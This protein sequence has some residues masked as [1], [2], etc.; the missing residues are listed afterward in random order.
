M[1][2]APRDTL[3][4]P[5]PPF[6]PI[7]QRPD[8]VTASLTLV[9]FDIERV[10]YALPAADVREI[11]RAVTIVPLPG[12]PPVIEGIIDVRGTLLPVADIRARL[13]HAARPVSPDDHLIVARAGD[14]VLVLRVDQAREVL[15]VDPEDLERAT[16][17]VPGAGY[18]SGIA[19]LP[20]GLVLVHD[21]R[22]LL[23]GSE[24]VALEDALAART[25]AEV[26]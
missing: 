8:D 14:R 6:P 18:L 2:S 12:A 15:A 3:V 9:V 25:A 16:S 26:R 5:G 10:S 17:V 19:R 24:G 7:L 11:L 4:Q 20:D 21:L 13:G 1:R 23:T 22:M